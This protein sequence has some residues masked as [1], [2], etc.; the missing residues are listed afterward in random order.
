MVGIRARR[1]G[2]SSA[3]HEVRVVGAP[4]LVL[5]RY[6]RP[7]VIEE[8]P[9]LVARESRALKVLESV[10]ALVTPTL[11]AA[12]AD[13]SASGGVPCLLMSR[14]R[15]RVEWSPSAKDVDDWLVR[16]AAV[17]VPLHD[18]GLPPDHGIP[19]F[20][21]YAPPSWRPPAWLKHPALWDRA[22][23]V[24]HA[25]PVDP[26]RALVHRDHHPGNV[27]WSRRRIT[28]VVDWPVLSV[29][30]PSVDAYWCFSNLLERFGPGVADRY[31]TTWEACSGRAF[32]PWAEVVMSLDVLGGG[33]GGRSA[34]DRELLE[35]RL[36]RALAAL[37][38]P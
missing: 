28:G 6:V 14:I 27:L 19:D 3:I 15:G 36:G 25:P 22:I 4:T 32:H 5:R 35:D 31:L 38:T 37:G 2:S 30:P 24:F 12:D 16:L 29:G 8:E 33:A 9:D 10:Q 26:E 18:A 21:P 13:G 20:A 34:A 7:E 11:V 23:D 1:G 17:L